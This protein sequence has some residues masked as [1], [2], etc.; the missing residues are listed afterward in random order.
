MIGS[1][2]QPEDGV[3]EMADIDEPPQPIR[4]L[5]PEY[6]C[7]AKEEK[8]EGRVFVRF[9]VDT[10]GRAQEPEVIAAEPA[11]V[12]ES[13]ALEAIALYKFEPALTNGTPVNCIAKMPIDFKL[14]AE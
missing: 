14:E 9:V 10:D 5:P 2:D 7:V 12:F 6:P 13:A 11:G 8:I 1:A 4:L 3:Y